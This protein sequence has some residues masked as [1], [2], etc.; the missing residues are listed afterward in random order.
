LHAVRAPKQ[1]EEAGGQCHHVCFGPTAPLLPLQGHHTSSL[2]GGYRR[3]GGTSYLHLQARVSRRLPVRSLS[4][5]VVPKRVVPPPG[6]RVFLLFTIERLQ[7]RHW[8]TGI[9]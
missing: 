6:G 2:A 3:F 9:T 5:A 4:T 1:E 8:E 7:T